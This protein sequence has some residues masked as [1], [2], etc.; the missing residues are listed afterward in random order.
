MCNNTLEASDRITKIGTVWYSPIDTK[1]LFSSVN[2]VAIAMTGEQ[3]TA[4]FLTLY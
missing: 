3:L 4:R 1:V 2:P